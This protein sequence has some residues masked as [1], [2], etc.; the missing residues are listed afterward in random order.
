MLCTLPSSRSKSRTEVAS[1]LPRSLALFV[2]LSPIF[3][4]CSVYHNTCGVVAI[5]VAVERREGREG[6]RGGKAP[7]HEPLT[8]VTVNAEEGRAHRQPAENR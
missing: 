4:Q 1:S 3:S 2:V 6:K 5:F 8:A 7:L